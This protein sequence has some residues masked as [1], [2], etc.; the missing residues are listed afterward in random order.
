MLAEL[1]VSLRYPTFREG[2]AAIVGQ[3]AP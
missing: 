1:R 2:L 3:A